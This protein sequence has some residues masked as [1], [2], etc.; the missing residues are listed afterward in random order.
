MGLQIISFQIENHIDCNTV[1]VWYG[2]F[3]IIRHEEQYKNIWEEETIQKLSSLYQKI[4]EE[5]RHPE[6]LAQVD[7]INKRL[8]NDSGT[9]KGLKFRL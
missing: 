2:I 6:I 7:A 3:P 4:T 8:E 5:E 9:Q 1:T